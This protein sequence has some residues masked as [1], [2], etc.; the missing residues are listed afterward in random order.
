MEN[1][2]ENVLQLG[3]KIFD[4]FN[5][6]VGASAGVGF[7]TK[8]TKHFSLGGSVDVLAGSY[9][10]TKDKLTVDFLKINGN[11]QVGKWVNL[12]GG[13]VGSSLQIEKFQKQYLTES[14]LILKVLRF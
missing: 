8:V 9:S 1:Q 14:C 7:K 10:I 6:S 5:L 2:V 3:I 11:L 12:K 13:L 4:A